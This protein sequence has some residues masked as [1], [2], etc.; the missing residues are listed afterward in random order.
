MGRIGTGT[1]DAMEEQYPGLVVGLDSRSETVENQRANGR[2]TLLGDATDSEFWH[3]L[4]RKKVQVVMITL[5]ELKANLEIVNSLREI[6]FEGTIA[7][8]AQFEDE[9]Q[10]LQE[11]G[12]DA[13]F[14]TYAESGAGF[15]GHVKRQIDL[16]L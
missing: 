16:N 1:Y 9:I 7:A 5:P 8:L 12:A 6:S 4:Q 10:Q 3:R 2:N 11:A 13:V 14:D 15:A